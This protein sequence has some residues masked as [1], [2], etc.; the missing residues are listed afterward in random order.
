MNRQTDRPTDPRTHRWMDRWTDGP[1]DQWTDGPMDRWTDGT[2]NRRTDV[3][4]D[5]RTDGPT[6]RRT[7]GTRKKPFN[8]LHRVFCSLDRR[9]EFADF[10]RYSLFAIKRELFA[11]HLVLHDPSSMIVGEKRRLES[12]F[13]Q[14]GSIRGFL[15]PANS[16]AGVYGPCRFTFP[17]VSVCVCV[18][19]PQ[20]YKVS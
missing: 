11:V 7:D 12:F 15:T 19:N 4:M 20:I 18:S 17:S 14:G 13:P 9:S 1:M 2:M 10:F 5:R 6:D 16:F 8:L 3:P